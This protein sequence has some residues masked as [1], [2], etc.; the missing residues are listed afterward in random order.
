MSN[1]LRKENFEGLHNRRGDAPRGQINRKRTG[2]KNFISKQ[3]SEW[4]MIILQRHFV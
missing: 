3:M 4:Q 2:S 1:F